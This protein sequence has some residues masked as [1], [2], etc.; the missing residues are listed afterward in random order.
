MLHTRKHVRHR[1]RIRLT[2]GRTAV[3]TSDIGP[4]GF[5]AE[6]MRALPAGAPV[7]GTIR[8]EGLE[9]GY[10]GKVVWSLPGDLRVNVRG[11]IGVRFT[12]LPPAAQ[13]F[14]ESASFSRVA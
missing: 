14:M 9:V 5:S 7:E 2:I 6:M 12:Q 3:F 4:G 1:R 13:R 11:R 10:V 8:L